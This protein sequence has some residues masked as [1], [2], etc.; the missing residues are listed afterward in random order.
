MR[1]IISTCPDCEKE[2]ERRVYENESE[3]TADVFTERFFASIWEKF[4]DKDHEPIDKFCKELMFFRVYVYHL[5]RRR[6]HV[7]KDSIEQSN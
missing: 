3:G 7:A 5:N 6:I 1:I 4:K 2:H